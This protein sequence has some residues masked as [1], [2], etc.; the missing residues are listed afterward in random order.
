MSSNNE[1]ASFSPRAR[2]RSDEGAFGLGSKS[3]RRP[4]TRIASQS[5]LSPHAGRGERLQIMRAARVFQKNA[6]VNPLTLPRN[7][8][9]RAVSLIVKGHQ[10]V[11]PTGRS[12]CGSCG[13]G[14]VTPALGQP[15]I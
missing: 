12:G 14:L 4:L 5:D 7:D 2:R 1:R 13:R 9:N 10:P 6:R 3:R 8:N 11:T 15:V